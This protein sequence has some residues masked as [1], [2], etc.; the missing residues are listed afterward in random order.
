MAK[1]VIRG[2]LEVEGSR[3]SVMIGYTDGGYVKI[4]MVPDRNSAPFPPSGELGTFDDKLG[5]QMPYL[6][7]S[8]EVMLSLGYSKRPTERGREDPSAAGDHPPARRFA[9][10][11]DPYGKGDRHPNMKAKS[12]YARKRGKRKRRTI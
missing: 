11:T 10:A 12:K 5:L 8:G 9:F 4:T 1:Q 3:G 2:L 6:G 7:F